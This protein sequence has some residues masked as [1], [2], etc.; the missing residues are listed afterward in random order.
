MTTSSSESDLSRDLSFETDDLAPVLAAAKAT[1][2]GVSHTPIPT[3]RLA[4][5]LAE[6]YGLAG[7]LRHIATEKDDTFRLS[8]A[9]GYL[10]KVSSPHEQRADIALQT[11]T[12]LHLRDSAAE[13][14]VQLPVAGRDGRYEYPLRPFG[15]GTDEHAGRILRVLT[16][17]PGQLL[18][19][20]EPTLPQ[21]R[22]IGRMG[23]RVAA[24][25]RGF[26]HPRQDRTLIWD[27]R[28]F[29]RMRP[30]L[31]HLANGSGERALA[32]AVFD[33]FE[34]TVVPA[35]AW[36][37][38]QVV[39]GD[40]SPYNLVV[41]PAT[42]GYVRG[43]IDF[44]DVVRTARV[45][46]VVVG[47]ANLLCDDPADPWAKAVAFA[48][49]YLSIRP[50]TEPEL[51][52]LWIGAQARVVLRILMARWRAVADPPRRDYLLSHSS[53]DWTNLR[54]ANAVPETTVTDR[55]HAAAHP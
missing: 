26:S 33:R 9:E 3:D 13:L 39:H 22:A 21:V 47:M 48:E 24:A 1:G 54:L 16:W 37:P 36:L 4:A 30:L 29:H 17:L 6:H 12:M 51:S 31:R 35:L 20:A 19:D 46:D 2:L 11:A 10:V 28:G 5:L 32:E 49:G 7:H 55:L 43:V 40:F 15:P 38:R 52:Q 41:D 34:A 18:D 8:G 23:G 27:L 53:R 50:L 42:P 44:G 14:P 25:L 45:F